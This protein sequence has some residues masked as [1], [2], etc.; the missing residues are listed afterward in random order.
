MELTEIDNN[1]TCTGLLSLS[2]NDNS[3][4]QIRLLHYAKASV[5]GS[6]YTIPDQNDASSSNMHRMSGEISACLQSALPGWATLTTKQ[7][8]FYTCK[9]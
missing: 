8:T 6:V 1:L 7:W 2:D 4:V 5:W 9:A 3:S